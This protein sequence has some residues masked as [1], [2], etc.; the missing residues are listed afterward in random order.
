MEKRALLY[1]E[2][3]NV[4]KNSGDH[5]FKRSYCPFNRINGDFHQFKRIVGACNHISQALYAIVEFTT[6]S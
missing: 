4:I 5:Q 2:S 1:T 6:L 3:F